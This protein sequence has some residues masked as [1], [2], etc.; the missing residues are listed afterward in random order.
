MKTLLM[1]TLLGVALTSCFKEER[2]SDKVEIVTIWVAPK[3]Q[4]V[5]WNVAILESIVVKEGNASYIFPKGWIKGFNYEKGYEYLLKVKKTTPVDEIADAPGS[6]YELLE[7]LE[8]KPE[9]NN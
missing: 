4:M 5:N 2:K 7:V 9:Q 1:L 6:F 8:K 3:T